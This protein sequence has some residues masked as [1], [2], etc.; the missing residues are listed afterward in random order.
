MDSQMISMCYGFVSSVCDIFG[1]LNIE[2]VH[3][4]FYSGLL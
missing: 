1:T 3:I 2:K 4:C